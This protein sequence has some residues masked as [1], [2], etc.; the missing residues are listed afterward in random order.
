MFIVYQLTIIN[1]IE[2]LPAAYSSLNSRRL[3]HICSRAKRAK[4]D[5]NQRMRAMDRDAVAKTKLRE[6]RLRKLRRLEETNFNNDAA[7]EAE[8]LEGRER[9][10]GGEVQVRDLGDIP[11][12]QF[13]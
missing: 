8:V 13:W 12:E 11:P 10:A 9:S 6:E 3:H 7:E 2:P 5:R 1:Q 4:N